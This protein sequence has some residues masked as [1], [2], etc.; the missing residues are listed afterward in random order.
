MFLKL[1]ATFD[2]FV[3]NDLMTLTFD[4]CIVFVQMLTERFNIDVPHRF[5][6]QKFISPTSCD[7][8][9][10]LIFGLF[11]PEL[12]CSGISSRVPFTFLNDYMT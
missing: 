9:G 12:Q 3:S 10:S 5:V 1:E 8:C 7:H 6:E 2:S 11:H 4:F